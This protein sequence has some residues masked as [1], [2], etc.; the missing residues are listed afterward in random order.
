MYE[1]MSLD[2]GQTDF[3]NALDRQTDRQTD[4]RTAQTLDEKIEKSKQ[5]LRLAADMS[6]TYYGAPLMIAYSGGKDSDV[7]LHLAENCLLPEEFEMINGHTTVDAPETVYHIRKVF[8]RLN[9]KGI[10]TT[11]DYHKK[12]D[13][14]NETMWSLI[15]SKRLPP[16]RIARYCCRVLK[17]T[18]TPNRMCAVGVRAAESTNRKGRDIFSIYGKTRK[19][20]YFYSLSH[21]M[22][23]HKESQEIQDDN[24]DCT[25]IKTMKEH[26]ETVINPIYEWEDSDIWD[27]IRQNRI[28]VNS[29]YE[30]GY[31]R[32]GCIGCPLAPYHQ[33]IKEFKDF[34]KYKQMY[35]N[36]F[37]KMIDNY[38]L[39]CKWKTGEEV[40]D[41]WM[42]E[43]MHNVKG[44]LS[45]FDDEPQA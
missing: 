28:T 16:T 26:K 27:Y 18:T 2:I 33:R 39:T 9:D 44:Q 31:K 6:K 43:Y 23:V 4:R 12:P 3:D 8:K 40:F 13:G 22:E 41:W 15:V 5:A 19:D 11:I 42:E 35:I 37:Q 21:A 24:W 38:P 32:V 7:L 14:T 30:M 1:Q 20:A 45:L 25:L 29:M 36:A 10:K 17:E 34:P